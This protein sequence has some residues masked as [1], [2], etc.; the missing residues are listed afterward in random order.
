MNVRLVLVGIGL[1][2]SHSTAPSFPIRITAATA[3]YLRGK[4]VAFLDL[5]CGKKGSGNAWSVQVS[6][7]EAMALMQ[8]FKVGSVAQL[9]D[10]EFMAWHGGPDGRPRGWNPRDPI[11]DILSVPNTLAK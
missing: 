6:Q 1:V 10:K 5:E 8:K 3:T 2:I 4:P 11:T 9:E 7:A